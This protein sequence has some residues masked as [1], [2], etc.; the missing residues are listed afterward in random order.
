[1]HYRDKENLNRNSRKSTAALKFALN[2]RL[3]SMSAGRIKLHNYKIADPTMCWTNGFRSVSNNHSTRNQFR[4]LDKT[5]MNQLKRFEKLLVDLNKS[6][7]DSDDVKILRFY[8]K[9][10]SYF[11]F[12]EHDITK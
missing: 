11:N 3:I 1:V 8:G 4:S 12:L 9:P 6:S 5:R 7:D 2:H 10:Y